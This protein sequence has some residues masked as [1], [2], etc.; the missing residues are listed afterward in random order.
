MHLKNVQAISHFIAG[1]NVDISYS[2]GETQRDADRKNTFIPIYDSN[3]K[4]NSHST[5]V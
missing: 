3:R 4:G 2:M 1:H 5:A